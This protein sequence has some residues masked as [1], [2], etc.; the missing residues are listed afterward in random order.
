[1]VSGGET[2]IIEAVLNDDVQVW[3][4]TREMPP[5]VDSWN[6]FKLDLILIFDIW[7]KNFPAWILK[8]KFLWCQTEAVKYI[9]WLCGFN[10]NSCVGVW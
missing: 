5:P 8:N 7:D 9:L 10:D 2:E 4:N 3:G 1:M 6:C